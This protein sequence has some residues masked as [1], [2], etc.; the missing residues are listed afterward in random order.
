MEIATILPTKYLGMREDGQY[1]MCLAHLMDRPAYRDFFREQSR[2]GFFVLMDNGVVETNEPL[3]M[4][5]LIE[6]AEDI[7]ATEM[8]LPDAIRDKIGRAHV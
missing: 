2:K 8:V 5:E 3:K 1:N 7:G 4:E 6:I